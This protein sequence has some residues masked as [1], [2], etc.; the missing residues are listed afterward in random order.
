MNA[1]RH[2]QHPLTHQRRILLRLCRVLYAA[3]SQ[4][5]QEETSPDVLAWE[6]DSTILFQPLSNNIN[7]IIYMKLTDKFWR[8]FQFSPIFCLVF[9]YKQHRLAQLRYSSGVPISS[10]WGGASRCFEI[11][12][13]LPIYPWKSLSCPSKSLLGWLGREEPEKAGH[14]S[15][16]IKR[17]NL[18]VDMRTNN[19]SR[20]WDLVTGLGEIMAQDPSLDRRV[21]SIVSLCHMV[22]SPKSQPPRCDTTLCVVASQAL[23]HEKPSPIKDMGFYPPP[24]NEDF[25]FKW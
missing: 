15:E 17:L 1:I 12:I 20:A 9:L 16:G 14:P 13:L 10:G 8:L 4:P 18:P 11:S 3:K 19:L 2:L 21:N 23:S 5:I 25:F 22:A 24:S 7:I 6:P